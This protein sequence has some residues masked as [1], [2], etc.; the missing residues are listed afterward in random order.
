MASAGPGKY[1]FERHHS[2][3][4]QQQGWVLS[5]QTGRRHHRARAG[6]TLKETCGQSQPT[7]STA[8]RLRLVDL[9]PA[10]DPRFRLASLESRGSSPC[11]SSSAPPG[12]P[13]SVTVCCTLNYEGIA[14]PLV[15]PIHICDEPIS[16]RA[17]AL[18][19]RISATPRAASFTPVSVQVLIH[20][21]AHVAQEPGNAR[22]ALPGE[23]RPGRPPSPQG[24]SP[25]RGPGRQA[26]RQPS[27]SAPRS[28]RLNIRLDTC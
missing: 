19:R 27:R 9:R 24:T 4:H 15:L 18:T 11:T 28:D 26:E 20:P 16:R 21:I 12:R 25:A 1:G 10:P 3:R 23:T 6:E 13:D 2:G 8:D 7:P 5:D 14:C 22:A 17:V